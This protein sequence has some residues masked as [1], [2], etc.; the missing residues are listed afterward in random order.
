MELSPTNPMMICPYC[1]S[2]VSL[3]DATAVYNRPGYGKLWLCDNYP[4]CDAYVGTHNQDD[5]PI[6]TLANRQLRQWRRN[7]HALFDPIWKSGKMSRNEAYQ[8]LC[9]QLGL[10]RE[11]T[12]IGMF[13]EARCKE[14]VKL[15]LSISSRPSGV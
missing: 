3:R 2:T 13:D 5:S 10:P 7:A 12:H 15:C 6:G 9:E 11:E 14:V 1:G 4:I 8:W